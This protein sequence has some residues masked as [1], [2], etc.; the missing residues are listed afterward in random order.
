LEAFAVNGDWFDLPFE[1]AKFDLIIGDGCT[2]QFDSM[3]RYQVFFEHISTK[4]RPNGSL[5]MRYFT[6]QDSIFFDVISLLN[7][8]EIKNFGSLKWMIAHNLTNKLTHEVCVGLIFSE[9]SKLFDDR[10]LLSEKTGWSMDEIN[11]IDSYEDNQ[12]VYTF[13]TIEVLN[14]QKLGILENKSINFSGSDFSE[15]CPIMLDIG[16]NGN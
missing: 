12:Q 14:T 4:L 13:P 6:R 1:N 8:K 10:E 2:T 16:I 9:F 15:Y 5:L 11:T 7:K 3:K